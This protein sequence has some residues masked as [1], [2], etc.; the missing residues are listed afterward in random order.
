MIFRKSIFL[1]FAVIPTIAA[2]QAID[3]NEY[4]M[5]EFPGKVLSVKVSEK[6]VKIKVL[7]SLIHI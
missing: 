5:T 7:L 3:L 2:A 1:L 6:K 4:L